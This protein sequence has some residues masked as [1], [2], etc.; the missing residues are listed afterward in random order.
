MLAGT[1]GWR[2]DT[3]RGLTA[4]ELYRAEIDGLRG[5]GAKICEFTRLAVD[6]TAASKPVLAGLF[7]TAYLYA[8]VIRGCTHGV[9]EVNPRHVAFYGGA[10]NFDPIGEERMNKRVDA[11]AVLLCVRFAVI[12][13]GL[14]RFAGKP[15]VPGA[16]RSL[17]VYGFP[18]DEEVGVLNRLRRLVAETA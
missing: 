4:D 6:K 16:G 15:D 2:L 9:I 18:P 12:A 17:F 10:L 7:H 14:K 13:D 1:V 11:P 8:S 3:E 5:D